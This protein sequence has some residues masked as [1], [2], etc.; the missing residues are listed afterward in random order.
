MQ[1][2]FL[3]T[4]AREGTNVSEAFLELID[5]ILKKKKVKGLP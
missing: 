2:K 3:E 1:L 4:S 5:M